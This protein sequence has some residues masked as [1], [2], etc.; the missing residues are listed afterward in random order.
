LFSFK[1]FKGSPE[2]SEID[3]TE[4]KFRRDLLS[5]IRQVE[6]AERY[7][8]IRSDYQFSILLNENRWEYQD[9]MTE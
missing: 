8:R 4:M 7:H 9:E 1:H 3:K 6:K 5:I 2:D